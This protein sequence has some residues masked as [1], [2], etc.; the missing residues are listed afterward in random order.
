MRPNLFEGYATR[1][2]AGREFFIAD[3]EKAL[4][5]FFYLNRRLKGTRE[6]F[7]SLRLQN[8]ETIDPVR[9]Q[10]YSLRFNGRV[11]RIAES[12]ARIVREESDRFK[13]L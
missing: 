7:E 8:L 3:P 10:A 1:T 9:L 11:R 4:L 6:E 5:D 13:R 12:L 2:D